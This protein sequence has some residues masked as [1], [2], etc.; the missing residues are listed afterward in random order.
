MDPEFAQTVGNLQTQLVILSHLCSVR[1]KSKSAQ[2]RPGGNEVGL[3][4][5]ESVHLHLEPNYSVPSH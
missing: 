1:E 4:M 3:M 2:A 5:M